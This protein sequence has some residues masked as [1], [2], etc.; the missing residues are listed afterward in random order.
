MR[1]NFLVLLLVF[2]VAHMTHSIIQPINSTNK[3]LWSQPK[4]LIV[5]P[6]G[7]SSEKTA[8][9]IHPNSNNENNTDISMGRCRTPK[10]PIMPIDMFAAMLIG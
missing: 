4:I 7:K 8:G 3:K 5:P 9:P 2:R 6:Q 10:S 1:Y